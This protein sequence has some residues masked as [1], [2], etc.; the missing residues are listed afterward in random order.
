MILYLHGEEGWLLREKLQQIVARARS[1]GVDEMNTADFEGADADLAKVRESVQAAPFLA[2]KRL[3]IIRDW[4]TS[5]SAE[6]SDQLVETL[7]GAAD[8]ATIIVV[9][10]HGAPDKRR[11]AVK[12]VAKSADKTWYFPAVD[13]PAAARHAERFATDAGAAIAPGTARQLVQQVG[14]DLWRLHSEISKLAVNG[15]IT[16]QNLAE[17]VT[18]NIEDDIFAFVDML[19]LRNLPRATTELQKLLANDEPPLRLLAMV[20]RQFRLLIATKSLLAQRPTDAALATALAIRP[21]LVPKMKKQ[22]S[23]F[24]ERELVEIYG[25]LQRIDTKLKLSPPDAEALLQL[26]VNEVCATS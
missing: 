25:D 23:S 12:K 26:F 22:S 4:L 3:I 11:G 17:L 13:A 8:P 6:E 5:R 9:V 21:F 10:E 7:V 20:V 14:T 1:Q 2:D 16:A 19:G 18:P 24:T 15:E